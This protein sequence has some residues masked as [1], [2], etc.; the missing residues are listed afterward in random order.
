M[1]RLLGLGMAAT[2]AVTACSGGDGD[3]LSAYCAQIDELRRIDQQLFEVD[4]TDSREADQGLERF[5][6]DLDEAAD[7]APAEIDEDIEALADW[8]VAVDAARDL[9]VDDPDDLEA[10]GAYDRALD[11]LPDI[12]PPVARIR[13]HARRACG[14]EL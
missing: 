11:A 12:A 9:L 3:D 14:I 8:L 5:L 2:L 7:L 6:A 13:S 4:P 10:L 1:R